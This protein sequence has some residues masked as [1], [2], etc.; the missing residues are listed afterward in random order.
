MAQPPDEE[1]DPASEPL[2]EYDAPESARRTEVANPETGVRMGEIDSYE[3]LVDG[4]KVAS[5]GA[6]NLVAHVNDPRFDSMADRFDNIR[7][8]VVELAGRARPGDRDPIPKRVTK[9][10]ITR[11]ESFNMIYKGLTDSAR[12]ARQFATG[13]RGDLNW[14]IVARQLETLRDNASELVRRRTMT[15]DL[16][17]T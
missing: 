5:E 2:I 1:I 11:I 9:A 8:K 13:H 4:L 6:R 3:R 12:C 17:I 16:I 14:T 7:V 10:K 15:S